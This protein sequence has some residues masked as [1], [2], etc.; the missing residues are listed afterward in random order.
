MYRVIM[1]YS[2]ILLFS[3]LI[4]GCFDVAGG[5]PPNWKFGE[6]SVRLHGVEPKDVMVSEYLC[7]EDGEVICGKKTDIRGYHLFIID[8]P[9]KLLPFSSRD[10]NCDSSSV[11]TRVI[12][13]V[14]K[15]ITYELKI[16]GVSMQNP[17]PEHKEYNAHFD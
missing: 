1:K 4:L 16:L 9:P 2:P 7:D 17:K 3:F 11:P 13:I 5:K 14:Y 12:Q 15:E 6:I 8:N 10:C